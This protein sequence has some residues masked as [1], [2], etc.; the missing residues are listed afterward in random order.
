MV[1]PVLLRLPIREYY[2]EAEV[3][4]FGSDSTYLMPGWRYRLRIQLSDARTAYVLDSR[5]RLRA[6][7][8][9]AACEIRCPD[10]IRLGEKVWVRTQLHGGLLLVVALFRGETPKTPSGVRSIVGPNDDG[11]SRTNSLPSAEPSRVSRNN[12]AA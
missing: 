1:S 9:R 3:S 5:Y 2:Q 12:R 4:G 10:D 8:P 11:R 7:L 6:S